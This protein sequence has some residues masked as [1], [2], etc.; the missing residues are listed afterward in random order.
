MLSLYTYL[1]LEYNR[2]IYIRFDG[3][4]DMKYDKNKKELT[5]IRN[6]EEISFP[7]HTLMLLS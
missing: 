4:T 7:L 6:N 1:D 2:R 3:V 5:L